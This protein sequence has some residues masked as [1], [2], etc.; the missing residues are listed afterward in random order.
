MAS[1][2]SRKH[3][4][5][6][7]T[8]RVLWRDGGR[9]RSLTF[10]TSHSAEGFR[11]NIDAYGSTGSARHPRHHRH[12]RR[13]DPR[14]M[15]RP[16]RRHPGRDRRRHPQAVPPLRSPRPRRAAPPAT[17][18][19]HRDHRQEVAPRPRSQQ[20][21]GQDGAEQVRI[22]VRRAE[23]GGTG[24]LIDRNPLRG[25]RIK[26]TERREMVML[27]RDEFDQVH[28]AIGRELWPTS[29]CGWCRPVCG[30]GRRPRCA[31]PTSTSMP[32]PAGSPARGNGPN[33]GG[34]SV[35][36]RRG[37]R[38]APSTCPRLRSTWRG[39]VR[40]TAASTCSSTV[41]GHRYVSRTSSTRH[42]AEARKALAPKTPRIHDLRHTCASWMIGAGV[43]LVV[44]SRHL[45]QRGHHH[46]RQH[47]QPRRSGVGQSRGRCDQQ[48]PGLGT[49]KG[50]GSRR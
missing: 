6:S 27:S 37:G 20:G 3:K 19:D 35:R 2:Q 5:G 44:V 29:R 9:Q 26:R 1:I 41:P 24:G 16:V 12:L 31:P 15:G 17:T 42:G 40:P 45:G 33:K 32:A 22:P 23:G 46:D 30:S 7:V 48:N 18:G 11:S 14:R 10:K 21:R 28:A 4:D 43:P 34:R 38:C 50:P 36:R 13:T 49:T 39:A 8:H 25:Q 47:V